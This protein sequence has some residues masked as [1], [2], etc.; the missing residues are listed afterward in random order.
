[1]ANTKPLREIFPTANGHRYAKC[2]I[3]LNPTS[4]DNNG[5]H[6]CYNINGH[7]NKEFYRTFGKGAKPGPVNF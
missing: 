5:G 6:T 4:R 3:C 1:M 2:P 7:R